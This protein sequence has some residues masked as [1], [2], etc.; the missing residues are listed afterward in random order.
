MTM[1]HTPGPWAYGEDRRGTKRVFDG[2]GHEVVRAMSS[3][4]Y[5]ARRP[6]AER[7]ANARLIAAA[8]TMRDALLAIRA[9]LR[10]A[11]EHPA[12]SRFGAVGYTIDD[13]HAIVDAALRDIDE[14][15]GG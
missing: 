8:P 6:T 1:K 4:G 15:A 12:R 13:I 9:Q 5:P 2:E 11:W 3:A 7:E 10:G 14:T